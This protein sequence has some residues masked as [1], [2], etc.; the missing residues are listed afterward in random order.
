MQNLRLEFTKNAYID[1]TPYWCGAAVKQRLI[2]CFL[3]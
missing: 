1:Y 2:K 3:L